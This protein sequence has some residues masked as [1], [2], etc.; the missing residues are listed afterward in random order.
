MESIRENPKCDRD[1]TV[2][3]YLR[4]ANMRQGTRVHLAGVGDQS[5]RPLCRPQATHMPSCAVPAP[6]ESINCLCLRV[7]AHS[8]RPPLQ[9]AHV[10]VSRV[11]DGSFDVPSSWAGSLM[12]LTVGPMQGLTMATW[13]LKASSLLTRPGFN[14]T[15][16]GFAGSCGD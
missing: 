3:G 8:V 5:V 2:Y 1:V 16:C 4:G 9:G 12:P 11:C 13:P 7:G 6:D 14:Q 15:A 10:L